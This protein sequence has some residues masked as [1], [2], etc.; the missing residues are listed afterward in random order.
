MN[1]LRRMKQLPYV[2]IGFA[3]VMFIVHVICMFSGDVLY[4]LG[5]LNPVAI[6][7]KN[8]YW[9]F[10]TSI[11]LHGSVSHLFNNLIV[12]LFMGTMLEKELG[13]RTFAVLYVLVGVFGN[14]SSFYMKVMG[15]YMVPSIGA[16]GVA[17]GMDG[18]LLSLLLFSSRRVNKDSVLRVAFAILLSLYCGFTGDHIDNA[19]H[20]GGL[21]AGFVLGSITCI[22]NRRMKKSKNNSSRR[23]DMY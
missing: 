17:F 6:L 14:I 5:E 22:I 2:N 21:I 20:V 11:F 4:D 15:H 19:A 10:F 13:H 12:L 8:E 9:R 7:T 23:N 16:S 18:I 3:A 1:K